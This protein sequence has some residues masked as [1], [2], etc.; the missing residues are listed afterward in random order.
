[1]QV[2][3]ARSSHDEIVG[4]DGGAD[5]IHARQEWLIV[6]RQAG[7]HRL[8]EP[9][10]KSIAVHTKKDYIYPTLTKS[11]CSLLPLL[12]QKGRKHSREGFRLYLP[13]LAQ[14]I[15]IALKVKQLAH[16]KNIRS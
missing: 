2:G 10:T 16:R 15:K 13:I 7:N 5:E 6:F 1:M 8:R 12:I 11:A 3:C 9:R 4:E 14:L